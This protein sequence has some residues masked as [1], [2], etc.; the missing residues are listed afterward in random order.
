MNRDFFLANEPLRIN[1]VLS[2]R[3]P[4]LREMLRLENEHYKHIYALL[5]QKEQFGLEKNPIELF[6]LI[7][8]LCSENEIF[9]SSIL[10][11]LK[12]FFLLPFY[13]DDDYGICY[14]EADEENEYPFL[15]TKEDWT[16][17]VSSIA[18]SNFISIDQL[19]DS[20]RIPEY[21]NEQARKIAERIAETK[22]QVEK[23]KKPQNDSP[24]AL[25]SQ[26]CAKSYNINIMQVWD[27]NYYQFITQFQNL[28]EIEAYDMSTRAMLAGAKIDKL[29]HWSEKK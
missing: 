14:D 28:L 20:V 8:L 27:L 24:F 7:S 13:W 5:T 29:T 1:D 23:Y 3:Y 22:R 15:L 4:T 26:F 18:E 12:Y 11:G 17:I 16:L 21:A 2:L 9:R 6:D 10:S 25:V 19:K